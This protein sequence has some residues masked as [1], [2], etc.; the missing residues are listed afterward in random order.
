MEYFSSFE[1]QE[2]IL[3]GKKE[4]H[5]SLAVVPFGSVEQHG[6]SLPIVTDS[7]ISDSLARE[8]CLRL[9]SVYNLFNY[10]CVHY[11]PCSSGNEY[12]GNI[13]VDNQV[14]RDYT[15]SMLSNF[16]REKVDGVLIMNGH[17]TIEGHLKEVVYN[18][19]EFQYRK[20]DVK[21][22]KFFLIVNLYSYRDE[23]AKRIN[24]KIGRHADWFEFLNIYKILGKEYFNEQRMSRI[25]NLK[26]VQGYE[27][28]E[29]GFIGVPHIYRS[30]QGVIGPPLPQNKD[31][32]KSAQEMWD[33][34]LDKLENEIRSGVDGFIKKWREKEIFIEDKDLFEGIDR[35]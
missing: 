6:P 27:E 30:K 19:M 24:H 11:T 21:L 26:E 2:R 28:R 15:Q 18:L 23:F 7:L 22:I 10:P 34:L 4:K 1:I 8:L 17:G 32:A 16:L 20:S 13:S 3:R 31:Y 35:L 29:K 14:F 5:L 9:S 12:P 25:E 33:F